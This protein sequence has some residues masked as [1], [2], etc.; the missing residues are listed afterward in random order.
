METDTQQRLRDVTL[1]L[2]IIIGYA[3]IY[4]TDPIREHKLKHKLK[5]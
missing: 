2:Y 3:Y 1:T 5:T 4:F